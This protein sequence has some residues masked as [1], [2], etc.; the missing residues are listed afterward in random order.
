[1]IYDIALGNTWYFPIILFSSL[2]SAPYNINFLSVYLAILGGHFNSL[3]RTSY[4]CLNFSLIMSFTILLFQLVFSIKLW[5]ISRQR[6]PWL[7]NI[8]LYLWELFCW[9]EIT[10]IFKKG[11]I[12][13]WLTWNIFRQNITQ[14]KCFLSIFQ[15]SLTKLVVFS[16]WTFLPFSP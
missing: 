1:M 8:L 3:C 4:L 5:Q 15:K 11:S 6:K 2:L 10:H 13:L 14:F 9:H 7:F 12:S 16:E